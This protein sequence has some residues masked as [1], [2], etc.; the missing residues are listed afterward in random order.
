MTR[1]GQVTLTVEP[2][3][4]EVTLFA[5]KRL[6]GPQCASTGTHTTSQRQRQSTY[7]SIWTPQM[8]LCRRRLLPSSPSFGYDALHYSN[9][10]VVPT[11]ASC[12]IFQ[13][14]SHHNRRHNPHRRHCKR[15]RNRR[16]ESQPQTQP[17]QPAANA[18][19][20]P[21]NR[22]KCA[23]TPKPCDGSSRGLP[24]G[25][26]A[27]AM[28]SP[29]YGI[30]IVPKHGAT[31]AARATHGDRTASRAPCPPPARA[32]DGCRAMPTSRCETSGAPTIPESHPEKRVQRPAPAP[33][34]ARTGHRP[35]H[36][37]ARGKGGGG[38]GAAGELMKRVAQGDASKRE[39][40]EFQAIIDEIT[41]E[42]KKRGT[43]ARRRTGCW[44][45]A[46]RSATSPTRSRPYS[47]SCSLS[48]PRQTSATLRPPEGSDPLVV[49]LVKKALDDAKTRDTGAQDRRGP[50]RTLRM[51]PTSKPCWT[52][53]QARHCAR[54]GAVQ[55]AVVHVQSQRD[56]QRARAGAASWLRQRRRRNTPRNSSGPR[57]PPRLRRR[58]S[59]C[60]R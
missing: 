4:F 16:P 28:T 46:G 21:A 13:C 14:L 49:M 22:A 9:I 2:H 24:C 3:V 26:A 15:R 60:R 36:P 58:S 43:P 23:A 17:L 53:L 30:D 11:Q 57:A 51:R 34:E 19:P 8:A 39:L 41:A 50:R 10:S 5:V 18:P 56:A 12:P 44:S 32:T 33:G 1:L 40:E 6:Q 54:A 37:H 25:A 55:D 47:T 31:A 59:T 52:R 42:S 27:A 20:C 35:Y 45:T 7:H 38:P 48:N 29:R